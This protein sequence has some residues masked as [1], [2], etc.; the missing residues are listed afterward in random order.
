MGSMIA[1]QFDIWSTARTAKTSGRRNGSSDQNPYGIRKLRELILELAV[2]GKL[3]SQDPDDEPAS[4]LLGKI[5]EE[6]ERFIKKGKIKQQKPLPGISEDEKFCELPKG[7]EWTRLGSTAQINPRNEADNNLATSFIPMSLI[8]TSHTGSHGQEQKA[9]GDIKSGYTHFANGDIGVAKITP[10]FE[11]SKAAVF[12]GLENG[13]GAGTTELYIVRPFGLTLIPRYLL[14]HLKSPLFLHTGE[15]KM[16]GTAGQKRL[17][18]S[19][20]SEMPLPLA[21]L[22]EQHRIV[23]KVDELMALCDQLELQQS[24]SNHA[25]Q[26]LVETLLTALTNSANQNDT[27]EAWQCINNHFDTLFTTEQSVDMIKQTIL[28]LAVM[29]RLVRQDSTDEPASVLLKKVTEER[30]R[31]VKEGRIRGQKPLPEISEDEKSSQLPEGWEWARLSSC[32]DVRDGTHDSP[33]SQLHGF[34]L[35]TS[36]NLYT[37]D[38]DLTHASFI[39]EEDHRKIA[40][41]SRVDRYD[42]LFAMIGSIGNPVIVDTNAEFSIKNVALFKYFSQ[43]LSVPHYLRMVLEIA[44]VEMREYASGGVQPF[45]SLRKIRAQVFALPPLR[46]Q[47][48]IVAKVDELMALCDTLKLRLNDAQATQVQ[49]ADAIVE[50]AVL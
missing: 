7:W 4:I 21:P 48:R 28:Q 33:K 31:L 3:V 46:E 19:F 23:V 12:S 37:G 41:R 18:K 35:V 22:A 2:H 44:A 30:E 43:E 36:K 39:S 34:P 1:E 17:P 6:K 29:G 40:K 45:V 49:L 16:T 27:A 32:Y 38:L 15:T 9:W 47:H 11:N 8:S 10:C 42:I 14:L 20:L 25:H 24:D 26:T 5:A 13:I 50:Q